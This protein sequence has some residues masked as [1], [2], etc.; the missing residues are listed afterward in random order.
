MKFCVCIFV[1]LLLQI[2]YVQSC[3]EPKN[4]IGMDVA[5]K[6]IGFIN[7]IMDYTR[8]IYK[9]MNA[10]NPI[11]LSPLR[12]DYQQDQF[13]PISKLFDLNQLQHFFGSPSLKDC[14]CSTHAIVSPITSLDLTMENEF[15]IIST[16][17][18]D[19][20]LLSIKRQI[21]NQMANYFSSVRSAHVVHMKLDSGDIMHYSRIMGTTAPNYHNQMEK[22]YFDQIVSTIPPGSLIYVI[23]NV[24][25]SAS[26]WSD[27][28][29]TGYEVAKKNHIQLSFDEV[30]IEGRELSAFIEFLIL[31]SYIVPKSLI[32]NS[33]I[34]FGSSF[35]QVI[36]RRFANVPTLWINLDKRPI[37]YIEQ[38]QKSSLVEKITL[39]KNKN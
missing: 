32:L 12:V 7:Q 20:V 10:S 13:I 1:F 14:V 37:C 18:V 11:C 38:K 8:H 35:S 5:K 25:P 34:P 21:T 33:G 23:G 26:I 39:L 36:S 3:I 19:S 9:Y 22:C 17:W 31:D 4:A 28:S 27:L 16:F 24:E 6:G 30:I 15:Q 2:V 29:N